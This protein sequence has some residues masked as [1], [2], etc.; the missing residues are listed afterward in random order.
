MTAMTKRPWRTPRKIPLEDRQEGSLLLL[1]AVGLMML[2][3]AMALAVDVGRFLRLVHLAQVTV[4][5]AALAAAQA[6]PDTF[7]ARRVAAN[8][9][10]QRWPD[11]SLIDDSGY[12]HMWDTQGNPVYAEL[13]NI[14]ETFSQTDSRAKALIGVSVQARFEPIF[15]PRWLY[16][17]YAISGIRRSARVEAEWDDV[18]YPREGLNPFG[19]SGGDT[20][21]DFALLVGGDGS[22]TA[23]IN[24]NNIDVCGAAHFNGG[25]NI[26]GNNLI[27]G[28]GSI[29]G[30]TA[31]WNSNGFFENGNNNF[32][33]KNNDNKYTV[34]IDSTA[35]SVTFPA[36]PDSALNLATDVVLDGNLYGTYYTCGAVVDMRTA[37][38]GSTIVKAGN[39]KVTVKRNCGSGGNPD[40]WEIYVPTG[41]TIDPASN[42]AIAGVGNGVDIRVHGSAKWSN[43][44]THLTGSL[45][46][47]NDLEINANNNT[48]K[49]GVAG[50]KGDNNGLVLYTGAGA[51]EGNLKVNGNFSQLSFQ[52]LIYVDGEAHLNGNG[53]NNTATINGAIWVKKASC[54]NPL[55]NGNNWG[56][57]YNAALFNPSAFGGKEP[58]GSTVYRSN[59]PRAR[60]IR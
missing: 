24:G 3:L 50:T 20:V 33:E 15:T 30:N 51:T 25:T 49:A 36:E 53:S 11:P 19:G 55:I 60:L 16:G 59:T 54:A 27:E 28:P 45:R 8:Y 52:G 29:C 38:A 57:T 48:F 1:G 14:A 22:C 34:P 6:L 44:N 58:T 10:R 43:N 9:I 39:Q 46:T 12:A 35:G 31:R 42:S 17:N 21:G 4:D 47:T 41:K 18:P 37:G 32:G 13:V 56:I 26:N 2:L 5:G 40:L 7:T 23:L